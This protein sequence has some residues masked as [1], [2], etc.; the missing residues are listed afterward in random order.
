MGVESSVI[1]AMTQLDLRKGT[2]PLCSGNE[3]VSERHSVVDKREGPDI[4]A[5]DGELI[6][7][8]LCITYTSKPPTILMMEGIEKLH[9]VLQSYICCNCGYTQMFTEGIHAIKDKLHKVSTRR[10]KEGPYR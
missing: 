9:G 1:F 2:C 3:V 7:R 4:H 6:Q 5:P 10:D 8:D